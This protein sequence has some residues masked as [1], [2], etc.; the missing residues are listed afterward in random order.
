LAADGAEDAL[1]VILQLG[2]AGFEAVVGA[3]S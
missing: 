3:G 1:G 2:F